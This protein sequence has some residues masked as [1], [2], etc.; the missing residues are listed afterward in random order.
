M[1][2]YTNEVAVLVTAILAV[3]VGSVWY[4]PLLFGTLWMKS[5]G[6]RQEK[7][8]DF[9]REMRLMIAKAI[10]VHGVFFF[11]IAQFILLSIAKGIGL[12]Y[13]TGLLMIL[14]AMNVARAAIWERRPF[15]YVLIEVGYLSVILFGGFAII[16]QWPW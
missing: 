16:S 6:L 13:I 7:G 8:K 5:V 11:A 10:L 9:E 1:F 12:P 2:E 15:A 14:L 3:A 4:S